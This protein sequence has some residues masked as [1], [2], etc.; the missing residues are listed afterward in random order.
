MSKSRDIL[1]GDGT[2]IPILYEDR[3]VLAIDKPPGWMLA[4]SHWDR[5]GRNLQLA[6]EASLKERD[7]WVSSRNLK[8]LRFLHRLDAETSGLLL[9]ARNPGVV[10]AYQKLF[11]GRQVDKLYLAVVQ[12]IPKDHQWTCR[13]ALLPD[14]TERGRIKVARSPS[15]I[16]AKTAETHFKLL[17]SRERRSLLLAR[18]VTG[19]THQIRVHLE[20]SGHPVLGDPLYGSPES[21]RQSPPGLGLRAVGIAY[22]EPFIAKQVRITAPAEAFALQYG[23]KNEDLRDLFLHWP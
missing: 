5:T 10:P 1:L 9:L 22:R 3:N 20:A 19:R 17:A 13:A 11:E 7:F 8:F 12:G 18:P 15:A 14:A 21:M 23:F 4:P 16:D 2:T 6:L